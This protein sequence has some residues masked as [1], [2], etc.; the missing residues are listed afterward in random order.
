LKVFPRSAPL[1][2][3]RSPELSRYL[4]HASYDCVHNHSL[5]LL[6]LRY[7]AQTARRLGAPLVISPR[8]MLSGWAYA[9][10]RWR[11][12][13][14]ELFIHPGAFRSAAGWHATSPEEAD[15]I[16]RLGFTQ[17]VC[18]SPNGVALP[19]PAGLAAQRTAWWKKFSGLAERPV[20]LFYSRFHRKKRLRELI[21]L[22]QSAPR[23]DWHLLVAGIPEEFSVAEVQSW[24]SS[25]PAASGVTVADST[26]MPPP[27]AIASLFL[28]PSHSENFGLVVAEALAAGVPALVTDGTPWRGLAEHGSGW[29]VTWEEYPAALKTT[30]ATDAAE[31]TAMGTRARDWMARD[32]SWEQA[33]GRLRQF[34]RDLNHA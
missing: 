13:W 25:S 22:W 8:G 12:R 26:G 3:C 4:A 2:L 19:S 14:A 24:I 21:E 27:Y 34:Y 29:C 5:W 30:L 9:H 17:P 31:L 23:G 28:L 10:H 7:A 32:F 16:R 11:K 33:A 15:D 6:T 20:A 18:V 1:K